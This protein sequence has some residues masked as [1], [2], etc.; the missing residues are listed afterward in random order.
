MARSTSLIALAGAAVLV[1]AVGAVALRGGV[2]DAPEPDATEATDGTG[3]DGSPTPTVTPSPSPT[4]EDSP[5]PSE[6]TPDDGATSPDGDGTFVPTEPETDGTATDAP[7]DDGT[8]SEDATDDTDTDDGGVALGPTDVEDTPQTG[9]GGLAALGA[10]VAA[11]A[12]AAGR[13]RDG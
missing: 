3:D 2:D 1:I 13:R 8:P 4:T 12:V 5:S 10:A 11:G 6:T 7:S 9:G